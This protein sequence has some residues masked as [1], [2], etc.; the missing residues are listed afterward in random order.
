MLMHTFI[1][2]TQVL[3]MDIKL[4]LKFIDNVL[5]V[6]KLLFNF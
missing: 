5:F 1:R 4:K 2:S 6:R 3:L